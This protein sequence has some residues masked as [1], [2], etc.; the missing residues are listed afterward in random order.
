MT[1]NEIGKVVVD[2][3]VKEHPELGLGLVLNFRA[4]LMKDGIERVVNGLSEENLG[5][6]ASLRATKITSEPGG[7]AS[8]APPHRSPYRSATHCI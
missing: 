1:E 2:A 8:A 6:F 5:V 4:N 7:S 3:A